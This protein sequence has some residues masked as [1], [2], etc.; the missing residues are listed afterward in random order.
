MDQ[1]SIE[2]IQGVEVNSQMWAIIMLAFCGGLMNR[3][4][5][6]PVDTHKNTMSRGAVSLTNELPSLIADKNINCSNYE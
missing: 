2:W 1:N 5:K 3:I 4:G 6:D